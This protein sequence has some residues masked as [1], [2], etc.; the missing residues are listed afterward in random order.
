MS[1]GQFTKRYIEKM[2]TIMKQIEPNWDKEEIEDT[3]EKMIK[4]QS[5]D[6]VVKLDNSYTHEVKDS[7]VLSVLDWVEERKPIIAGNAAFFKN[8][9]EA[10]NPTAKMLE[11]FDT[12]RSN[13][14]DQM[15]SIPDSQ[16]PEY[17]YL[18]RSQLNEKINAN[19]WYG[20]QSAP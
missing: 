5:H 19:S 12:N 2:T 6:P 10:I 17:K 13:L 20:A 11:T 4:K 9:H 15:F 18:D 3:I 16:S 1:K 7:T 14:K 8:Q